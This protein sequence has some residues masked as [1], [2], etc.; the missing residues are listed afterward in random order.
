MSDLVTYSLLAVTVAL[1]A[2]GWVF[3]PQKTVF[4]LYPT[5]VLFLGVDEFL[6]PFKC[7]A[8]I[9]AGATALVMLNRRRAVRWS[10]QATCLLLAQAAASVGF[11]LN[12]GNPNE[13]V[14]VQIGRVMLALI[15]IGLANS[16]SGERA[17]RRW[18]QVAAVSTIVAIGFASL[19]SEHLFGTSQRLGGVLGERTGDSISCMALIALPMVAYFA[20]ASTRSLQRIEWSCGAGVLVVGIALTYTRMGLLIL[21]ILAIWLIKKA[22][23]RARFWTATLA[24]AM[25]AGYAALNWVSASKDSTYSLAGMMTSMPLI[26]EHS[27]EIRTAI[28][29]TYLYPAAVEIIRSHPWWGVGINS[30]DTYARQVNPA[31]NQLDFLEDYPVYAHN[32]VLEIVSEQGLFVGLLMLAAVLWS[33]R[34]L[35][36][37]AIASARCV[38]A[39]DSPVTLYQALYASGIVLLTQSL[40]RDAFNDKFIYFLI[41]YGIIARKPSPLRSAVLRKLMWRASKPSITHRARISP[42]VQPAVLSKDPLLTG[43]AD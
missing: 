24:L 39:D 26:G 17:L 34:D 28:R 11:F 2:Y 12:S 27:S 8:L 14:G 10:P 3:E 31:I 13:S 30:F 37:A 41:G 23:A 40:V 35:R 29:V 21:V 38:L 25:F 20:L 43:S 1:G 36:R 16:I 9:W 7:A 22:R 33:M 4:L 19:F 42:R 6:S 18:M 15:P 32:L 5:A